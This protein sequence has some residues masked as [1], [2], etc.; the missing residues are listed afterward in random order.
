MEFNIKHAMKRYFN[1]YDSLSDD[2]LPPIAIPDGATAG[3]FV[4][5]ENDGW[6]RWR[7]KE[8]DEYFDLF[9]LEKNARIEIHESIKHLIN[10]WWFLY[11]NIQL[12]DYCFTIDPIIPGNY[13]VAFLSKLLGYKKAHNEK[14]DYI[15]IGIDLEK[16][17]LL[18]INN[19]TGGV[20]AE[21][22]EINEYTPVARNL[23]EFLE[24]GN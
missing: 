5:V 18:V 7:P 16:D 13:K 12:N 17:L 6:I 10:S 20:C 24:L 3:I 21:N 15:P 19:K 23:L 22:F 9:E 11:L 4:G 8:K 14:L 1:W 2:Q